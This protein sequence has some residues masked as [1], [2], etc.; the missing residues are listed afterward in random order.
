MLAVAQRVLG[1]PREAEDLVHD[2]FL[3]AWHRARYYEPARGSVRTW[4]MMRLRSRAIDRQRSVAR[5]TPRSRSERPVRARSR[6][7]RQR[8]LPATL[9][10]VRGFLLELSAEHQAVLE[11][12]YF[13]GLSCAEI[14]LRLNVP[15]GTVKSRMS[16]AIAQLR[17]RVLAAEEGQ[18]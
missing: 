10:T 5:T 14:A 11:L 2:V 3:E 4:L 6:D 7:Q 18:S 13:G 12:G 1:S 16:R 15:M 8:R 17:E 9:A